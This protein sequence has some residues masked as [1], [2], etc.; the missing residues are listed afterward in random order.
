MVIVCYLLFSMLEGHRQRGTG[1]KCMN[2]I[3]DMR[4]PIGN[5]TLFTVGCGVVIEKE[6]HCYNQ[7]MP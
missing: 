4:K 2:N 1:E 5:E 6:G 7:L 3:S